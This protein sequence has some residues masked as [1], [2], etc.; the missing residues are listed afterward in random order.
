MNIR[1]LRRFR[2]CLALTMAGTVAMPS[3]AGDP[4]GNTIEPLGSFARRP[5]LLGQRYRMNDRGDVGGE[6]DSSAGLNSDFIWHRTAEG[7]ETFID[8]S[9]ANY[10]F[11]GINEQGEMQFTAYKSGG[12]PYEPVA[13]YRFRPGVGVEQLMRSNTVPG[14]T[15]GFTSGGQMTGFLSSTTGSGMRTVRFDPGVGFVDIGGP[16]PGWY[17]EGRAIN[18]SGQ[19]AAS[20]AS[21]ATNGFA[22]VHT[23]GVGWR[24]VGSLGGGWTWVEGMNDAGD[25]VGGARQYSGNIQPFVAFHNQQIH[26][27]GLFPGHT[28]GFAWDINNHGWVIGESGYET[29]FLWTAETG[30]IELQSLLPPNS[31]WLIED[32]HDINN[33]GQIVGTGRLGSLPGSR[34]FV[35]TIT[36]LVRS[37]AA[38]VNRD[39]VIN[40]RDVSAVLT[41]IG[42]AGAGT[43][44]DVDR[45]GAVGVGDLRLVVGAIDPTR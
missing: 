11:G 44:G 20:V 33:H 30:L 18:E 37:N 36:T 3:V 23:P 41:N 22:A 21:S 5:R 9:Q 25:I 19:V 16:T 2:A 42:Q 38:D 14:N 45:D 34:P 10:R 4:T 15:F 7:V 32:V 8:A 6:F 35:L 28:V 29:P 40:F 17:Q 12:S 27:L 43:V 24:V 31:G 1:T 39:G 13:L 26:A